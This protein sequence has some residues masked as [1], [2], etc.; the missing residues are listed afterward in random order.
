LK[1]RR[2]KGEPME[3]L[4]MQR[5]CDTPERSEDGTSKNGFTCTRVG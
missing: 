4:V 1:C 3:S 2:M 5:G